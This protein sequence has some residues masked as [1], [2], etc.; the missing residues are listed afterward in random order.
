MDPILVK[1]KRL[2]LKG[3]YEFRLSA[4]IQLLNDGLTKD[5]ALEAILNADF[6]VKKRSTSEDRLMAR[7]MVY[8][9]ESFTFDG[10]LMYTKGT[11]RKVADGETYYIVIS[12]KRSTFGGSSYE[13]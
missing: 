5:D 11:I 3:K 4:E 9:I 7:E 6:L 1:I 13:R 2:V 12:S 10:I 8:V